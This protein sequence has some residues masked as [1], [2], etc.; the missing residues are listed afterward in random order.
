MFMENYSRPASA[1]AVSED[2]A[3]MRMPLC[4]RKGFRVF[5]RSICSAKSILLS[6]LQPSGLQSV[7]A[8]ASI[9]TRAPFGIA[10]TWN[11]ALAGYGSVKNSA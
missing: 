9:S 11:A 10:T 2:S 1:S 8:T 3:V 7:T 4:T 5:T 6:L